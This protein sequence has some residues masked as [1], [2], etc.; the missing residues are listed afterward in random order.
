MVGFTT[1]RIRMT[2]LAAVAGLA[3]SAGSTQAQLITN[4]S[5]EVNPPAAA[6]WQTSGDAT[7]GASG[8][9][10]ATEGTQVGVLGIGTGPFAAASGTVFQDFTLSQAGTFSYGFDAGTVFFGGFPFDVG[11]TFRIDDQVITSAL[12]TFVSDSVTFSHSPLSTRIAGNLVLAAGTHRFAFDLSRSGTLFGRSAAFVI[13]DIETGFAPALA[14]AVPE[15]SAWALLI[16]GF[17]IV[18]AGMRTRGRAAPAF[19]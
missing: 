15:P 7:V 14:G 5:F 1:I 2:P 16:L 6:G 9:N 11:F 4:G 17:G 12:P 13:D 19:A 18:G 8:S 3:L 10:L